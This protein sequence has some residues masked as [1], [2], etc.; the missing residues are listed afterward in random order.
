MRNVFSLS[1]LA[2]TLTAAAQVSMQPGYPSHR[3]PVKPFAMEQVTTR[4][5]TFADGLTHTTAQKILT[6]RDSN[7]RIRNENTYPRQA[8]AIYDRDGRRQRLGTNVPSSVISV[9]DPASQTNLNWMTGD[10]MAHEARETS[11]GHQT[12]FP[13]RPRPA[14]A[15][16][17]DSDLP[18]IKEHTE[19]LGTR[20]IQ[21]VIATGTRITTKYPAGY[22]GW[23]MERTVIRETWTADVYGW[24]VESTSDDTIM[25]K[26]TVTLVSFTEGEPD[27]ALFKPPS[28]YKI[29]R[30]IT[31][32]TAEDSP[33]KQQP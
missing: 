3:P 10:N 18:V 27:P 8:A 2:F 16:S 13:V 5:Q 26:T 19:S 32:I 21:G 11:Y 1:L 14:P 30:Q 17:S 25:G 22:D 12:L 23:N 20:A 33:E 15:P 24:I 6:A 31:Q 4:M 28:D 7:G 29:I 9:N